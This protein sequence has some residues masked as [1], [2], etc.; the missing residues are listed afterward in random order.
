MDNVSST[1]TSPAKQKGDMEDFKLVGNRKKMV[2]SVGINDAEYE[3]YIYDRST[4]PVKQIWVCPYYSRW[5]T[6]LKR[7]YS[8]KYKATNT[9]YAAVTVCDEWLR[10]SSFR[11]WMEKQDWQGKELDKDA[12]VP[13]NNLYHPYFCCFVPP[14][15]NKNLR[16]LGRKGKE[17]PLGVSKVQKPASMLN[18]LTNGYVSRVSTIDGKSLN[19]RHPTA[20]SAHKAWQWSKAEQ[21]EIMLN[22]YSLESCFD[23]RVAAG[24]LSRIW[25]L[26]LE[27][28]SNIETET[29]Y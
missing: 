2:Y 19:T 14:Y 27:F 7:A 9:S 4:T 26:R 21:L 29:F 24:I 25:K 22:M 8:E 12:I 16:F 13:G 15:L 11:A 10:F 1:L 20:V 6:M 5:N 18:E 3:V 17:L 23:T 28:S